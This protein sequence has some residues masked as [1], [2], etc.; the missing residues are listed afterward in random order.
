MSEFLIIIIFFLITFTKWLLCLPFSFPHWWSD[1]EKLSAVSH[2]Q[3]SNSLIADFPGLKTLTIDVSHPRWPSAPPAHP[4]GRYLTDGH[5]RWAQGLNKQAICLET[6]A[7]RNT[8]DVAFFLPD[9]RR[10]LCVPPRRT[11][12]KWGEKQKASQ[13]WRKEG[14]E[15]KEVRGRPNPQIWLHHQRRGKQEMNPNLSSAL[16][17]PI[18]LLNSA[19]TSQETR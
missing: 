1:Y 6:L 19:E 3:S 2:I 9:I 14:K 7:K 15:E 4:V 5:K 16:K 18:N 12:A 13:G 17:G 8:V 10:D 11:E